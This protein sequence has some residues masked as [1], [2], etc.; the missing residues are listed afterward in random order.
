[1]KRFRNTLEALHW[2]T[3]E[4][5]GEVSHQEVR[6]ALLTFVVRDHFAVAVSLAVKSV[7]QVDVVPRYL[8]IHPS[9]QLSLQ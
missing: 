7:P 2:F 4:L 5:M 6:H 9:L 1:M 3:C 8:L